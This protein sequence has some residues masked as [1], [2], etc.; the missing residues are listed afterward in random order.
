MRDITLSDLN[1]IGG[2]SRSAMR[3]ELVT[4]INQY[5]RVYGIDTVD[6]MAMFLA[7][8]R[9]ESSHFTRLDENLR[10]SAKQLVKIWR[11]R[12][13]TIEFAKQY[14]YRPKKIANF[15]YGN[16]MGNKGR[17][18][19]GWLYRGSGPGQITGYDNF[20]EFE[21][22]TGI[23]VTVNPEI[24]RDPDAGTKSAC[25]FWQNRNMNR[26]ADRGD[27]VGGRKVWN[28]G[29]HGLRLVEET[30]VIAKRVLAED[31]K[32]SKTKP[33]KPAQSIHVRDL[34]EALCKAGYHT[35]IDG[36]S[37]AH[38]A[39]MLKAFQKNHGLAEDG[40]LNATTVLA[41]RDAGKPK[42]VEIPPAATPTITTKEDIS[43]AFGELRKDR[44]RTIASGDIVQKISGVGASAAVVTTAID[45]TTSALSSIPSWVWPALIVT[46]A[47]VVILYIKKIKAARVDDYISG[48]T[49]D[50]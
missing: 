33:R 29:T 42:P 15:V 32:P 38:T 3:Q 43:K 37:G 2:R 18:N 20:K 35:T 16:R 25:L 17:R 4:A 23:A 12:F 24:L 13:P 40:I 21:D 45:Q 34:Q 31:A 10:Y 1:R 5:A 36:I 14:E 26:F 47:I 11:K 7:N 22:A 19:A 8:I 6:R 9:V 44:S 46:A 28:G 49:K 48:R 27:V 41:L 30:F 39:K 50:V